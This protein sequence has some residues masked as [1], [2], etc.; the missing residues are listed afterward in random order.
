MTDRSPEYRFFFLLFCHRMRGS[1][2]CCRARRRERRYARGDRDCDGMSS[3]SGRNTGSGIKISIISRNCGGTRKS[4]CTNLFARLEGRD[5]RR[6]IFP[7]ENLNPLKL[8]RFPQRS[9]VTERSMREEKDDRQCF[10]MGHMVS[11]HGGKNC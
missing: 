6:E 4:T 8:Y 5:D 10:Y 7:R 3:F 9:H 2:R 1:V 11:F